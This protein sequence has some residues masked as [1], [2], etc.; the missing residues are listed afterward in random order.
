LRDINSRNYTLRGMAER[1]A[2]NAPIQGSAADIIKLAM[3]QIDSF[4][5]KKH[6]KTKLIL[7]VHDELVFDVPLEELAE[8]QPQIISLMENV[9]QWPVPLKAEGGVGQNWLEA[10]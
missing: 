4:L 5:E 1:N 3:V 10:H 7:Q 2:I 9:V 8:V 6:Y